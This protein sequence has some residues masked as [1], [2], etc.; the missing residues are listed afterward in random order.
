MARFYVTTVNGRGTQKGSITSEGD[1]THIRGWNAGVK[2]VPAS[3]HGRDALEVY[4]TSGSN[5]GK[6]D[7]YIGTVHDT[8][9]GPEWWTDGAE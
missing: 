4:V 8:D 2:V 3:V 5:G 1:A 7:V 6:R 9:N